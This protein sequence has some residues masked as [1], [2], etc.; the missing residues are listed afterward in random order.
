MIN[1][2]SLLIP[3]TPRF[4]LH[5]STIIPLIERL[6]SL[7]I[8]ISVHLNMD[9]PNFLLN[10]DHES[11]YI[12][13]S[14]IV[15]KVFYKKNCESPCF[16]KACHSL[17]DSAKEDSSEFFFWIEDDWRLNDSDHFIKSL[18]EIHNY[19]ISTYV[20]PFASGPPFIFKRNVF[21]KI[22][23]YKSICGNIDPEK[24]IVKSI[25]PILALPASLEKHKYY[26]EL[27]RFSHHRF[28]M[29][30]DIPEFY[31]PSLPII[32]T[33]AGREWMIKNKMQ[34]WAKTLKETQSIKTWKKLN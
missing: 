17:L 4:D 3:A 30:E 15:E 22:Y 25:Y 29:R 34:K 32:F 14:K 8:N 20:N 27:S 33:D 9:V 24:I 28:G 21:D 18:E 11:T 13:I 31:D 5:K 12:T 19:D 10:S 7:N 16:S 6:K 23:E 26:Q 2:I 1:N